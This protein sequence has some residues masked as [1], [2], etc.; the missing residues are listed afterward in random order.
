MRPHKKSRSGLKRSPN[1]DYT[2]HT[3]YLITCCTRGRAPVLS[4]IHDDQVQFTSLGIV[5]SQIWHASA[6]HYPHLIL[7]EWIVM[8]DHVHGLLTL[9]PALHPSP[10]IALPQIIHAYKA[11]VTRACHQQGLYD[12]K[13]FWQQG[14]H[15]LIIQNDAHFER[16]RRY[17]IEN[18]MRWRTGR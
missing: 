10:V 18:P 13:T 16:A 17:I 3:T 9:A 7:H 1:H 5:T 4:E 11:H 12:R 6:K 15:D 2:S 14:F 8:P